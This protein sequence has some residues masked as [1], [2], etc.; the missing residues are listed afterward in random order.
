MHSTSAFSAAT[1]TIH[2]PAEPGQFFDILDL[3][4]ELQLSIAVHVRDG[5]SMR[6]FSQACSQFAKLSHAPA[7][8]S[9]LTEAFVEQHLLRLDLPQRAARVYQTV[10]RIGTKLRLPHLERL[11]ACLDP[12]NEGESSRRK[13]LSDT[14][15][16][17]DD[18]AKAESRLQR[19]LIAAAISSGK[20]DGFHE[21]VMQ[22]ALQL[23]MQFPWQMHANCG[24]ML[25]ISGSGE[26]DVALA[27]DAF[28]GIWKA[29]SGAGFANPMEECWLAAYLLRSAAPLP[30]QRKLPLFACIMQSGIMNR[31]AIARVAPMTALER[32][33]LYLEELD[34]PLAD[35]FFG[36]LGDVLAAYIDGDI[37]VSDRCRQFA[38]MLPQKPWRDNSRA[39]LDWL[40]RMLRHPADDLTPEQ[41]R[42]EIPHRI[43]SEAELAYLVSSTLDGSFSREA[44]EGIDQVGTAG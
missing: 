7:F 8:T 10:C 44:L 18:A 29:I 31:S 40:F 35:A 34:I 30:V 15:S 26:A 11:L 22:A 23:M 27:I 20:V 28:T 43:F 19:A 39:A 12:G 25:H 2:A 6:N 3:P 16:E 5:H 41:I 4:P 33:A 42:S 17:E 1:P 37:P 32:S 9:A 21:D 36:I 24:A 38:G 14:E 13:E